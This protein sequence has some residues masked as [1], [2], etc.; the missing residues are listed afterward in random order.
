MQVNHVW[1]E[2][3]PFRVARGRWVLRAALPVP[4]VVA[5]FSTEFFANDVPVTYEQVVQL[6]KCEHAAR[7]HDRELDTLRRMGLK[8]R[9]LVKNCVL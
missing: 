7:A 9:D 2:L 5:C 6:A 4:V 3:K 8:S 1:A